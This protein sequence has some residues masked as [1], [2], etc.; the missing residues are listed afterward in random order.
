MSLASIIILIISAIGII[1]CFIGMYKCDKAIKRNHEVAM[2]KGMLGSMAHD[3]NMRHIKEL[4]LEDVHKVWDWFANKW[5]YEEMLYS[6]KPLTLEEWYT[7]EE[8]ERINS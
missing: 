2:F 5:T 3:Y 8:I 6:S 4:A 1:I 7:P